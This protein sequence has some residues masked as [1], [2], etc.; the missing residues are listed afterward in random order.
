[1]TGTGEQT[2]TSD[3]PGAGAD[4]FALLDAEWQVLHVSARTR[5]LFGIVDDRVLGSS[6]FDNVHPVDLEVAAQAL[7]AARANP[8]E[9]VAARLRVRPITGPWRQVEIV[10]ANRLHEAGVEA[11]VITGTDVTLERRAAVAGSLE[12]RLLDSLPTALMVTDDAGVIVLWNRRATELYGYEPEEVLGHD[13]NEL[14]IAA[15]T[16]VHGEI[17]EAVADGGRWT[18]EF[19]SARKDGTAIPVVV[20]VDRLDAPEIGF[21]GLVGA[22]IDNSERRALQVTLAHQAL[23]DPLTGLPNRSLFLDRLDQ[24]LA[25]LRR[26]PG[27]I[28]VLFIDLDRFKL[29][30]DTCGHLAGDEV[31][32]AVGSLFEGVVRPMDTVARLGGDEFAVCCEQLTDPAEAVR[33]AERLTAAVSQP[34]VVEDREFYVTTSIG[35]VLGSGGEGESATTLLRDADSAMYHAKERGRGRIEIFDR[36]MRLEVIR[37][38][39]VASQLRHALEREELALYYQPVVRL[40]DGGLAGFEA[41]L[42]WHHPE[43]GVLLPGEF[44]D[45]AEDTNLIVPVGAWVLDE[46]GRQLASWRDELPEHP[47]TISVNLSAR[48]IADVGLVPVVRDVLARYELEPSRLCLEITESTLMEDAAASVATLRELKAL[49]VQLAIDDFGTGYSSLA[50]LKRFPVDFLKIDRSFVS[51]LDHETEDAVIVKAVVELGRALGLGVVAEGVETDAE[52]AELQRMGC[53]LAQGYR[54]AMPCPPAEAV[55]LAV[56]WQGTSGTEPM[57]AALA[58]AEEPALLTT[59]ELLSVLTHELVTPLTVVKGQCERLAGL[60]EGVPGAAEVVA[61]VAR[62]AERIEHLVATLADAQQLDAGTI[63]LRVTPFD[64]VELVQD[65]VSL[66]VPED[67]QVHL[68][69]IPEAHIEADGRRVEQIVV[70]LLTN[71]HK[72]SPADAPIVVSF[73]ADDDEVTVVVCDEGPG[74]PAERV[75]DIFR[76][77]ARLERTKKGVGLGLFISRRLARAHGGDLHYRRRRPEGSELVLTLPRRTAPGAGTLSV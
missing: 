26:T 45:V 63:A 25:R 37:K 23:H 16:E 4:V 13:I 21:H 54:W 22:G 19:V 24:A 7:L 32:R 74:V 15:P 57:A 70:N 20:T 43:R 14:P 38:A 66:A 46:A 65:V 77:F 3:V 36:G 68:V 75:G 62:N 48:Q 28:A 53:E 12:T 17:L 2:V 5:R 8:G 72:F 69:G 42:R 50:Y 76:K 73:A 18:G 67:R 47:I 51:G 9:P 71:A 10:V 31:L 29:V 58:H 64:M 30:N 6:V 41:L 49:G 52:L 27:N 40:A 55:R 56:E 44:M 34:F 61:A 1:M 39:E 59:T 11:Y 33:L 60:V 35:I